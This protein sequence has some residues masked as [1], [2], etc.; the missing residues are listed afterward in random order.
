M[1]WFF[2]FNDETIWYDNYIRYIKCAVNSA[3]ANTQLEPFFMYDGKQCALTDWLEANN[4]RVIY[5]RSRFYDHFHKLQKDR[6]FNAAVSSGAYL[7]VE[8]PTLIKNLDI[9]DDFVLYTDCDVMFQNSVAELNELKPRFFACSAEFS[10]NNWNY[11]NSG[12]MWL[13]V[14]AM[15]ASLDDFV[16]FMSS[17]DMTKFL[18]YDQAA[19]NEFYKNKWDK[20]A[21]A[22]NWKPYWGCNNSAKIIHF[23]GLKIENIEKILS[24]NTTRVPDVSLRLY[25]SSPVGYKKYYRMA[26]EFEESND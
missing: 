23:H 13:N 15:Q 16:G 22:Y 25:N 14:K 3:H 24:G 12:V 21:I 20:L 11:F 18:S 17:R 5:T 7:R 9:A 1:K 2:G 4:V 19:Y 10:Q 26:K 6:G 8:I